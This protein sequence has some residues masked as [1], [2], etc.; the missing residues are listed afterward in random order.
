[1]TRTTTILAL[2]AGAAAVGAPLPSSAMAAGKTISVCPIGFTSKTV[3]S[4]RFTLIGC[5]K[6]VTDPVSHAVTAYQATGAVNL[7]GVVLSPQ[8]SSS[9]LTLTVKRTVLRQT[10][11]ARVSGNGVYDVRIEGVTMGSLTP[12]IVG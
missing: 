8:V 11:P 2:V 12:N 3:T 5:I 10:T 1:M 4:D 9:I 6:D 7:G